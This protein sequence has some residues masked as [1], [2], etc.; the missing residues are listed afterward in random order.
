MTS[1]NLFHIMWLHFDLEKLNLLQHIMEWINFS[2][3]ISVYWNQRVAINLTP[4]TSQ[5][6]KFWFQGVLV[7]SKRFKF[8]EQFNN[9]SNV[10][11]YS[12][13]LLRCASVREFFSIFDFW[14]ESLSPYNVQVW[15]ILEHTFIWNI[16]HKAKKIF[17]PLFHNIYLSQTRYEWRKRR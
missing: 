1:Y 2:K 3:R 10:Q 9:R 13:A 15:K 14:I 6:S 17:N 7:A 12:C 8:L 5:S 16:N 4:L 11:W